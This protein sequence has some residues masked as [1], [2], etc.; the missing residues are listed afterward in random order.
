MI[1]DPPST[2]MIVGSV[3]PL[4]PWMQFWGNFKVASSSMIGSRAKSE[5]GRNL[6]ALALLLEQQKGHKSQYQL[7]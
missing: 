6:T 3:T 2:S 5:L 7:P 1:L 4:M